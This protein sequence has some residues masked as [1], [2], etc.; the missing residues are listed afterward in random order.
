MP[1]ARL[2]PR[3]GC[4]PW[5]DGAVDIPAEIHQLQAEDPALKLTVMHERLRAKFPR[6]Y[7]TAAEVAALNQPLLL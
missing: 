5:D 1:R 7:K 6:L 2:W 3:A 4:G